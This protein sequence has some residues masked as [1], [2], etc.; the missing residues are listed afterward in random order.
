VTLQYIYLYKYYYFKNFQTRK[1][2][3]KMTSLFSCLK[4]PWGR[5][6]NIPRLIGRFISHMISASN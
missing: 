5:V 6:M 4:K 2:T 1:K 3:A